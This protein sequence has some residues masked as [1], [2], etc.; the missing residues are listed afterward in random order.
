MAVVR[1]VVLALLVA[2]GGRYGGT[3]SA[4]SPPAR[5]I[6]AAALPYSVLDARTGRQVD[7]QSFWATVGSSRVVCV[8]EDHPNPHHHW[9]QLEVVSQVVG[10][11]KG[12]PLGLGMEMFQRPYQGVLDDYAARRIDTPALLSRS[13]WE[14]RWGYDYGLYGPTIDKARD[15]GAVLLALNAPRELVK[16]LVRQGLEAFTDEE[17]RLV[18]ELVL[19][20]SQHRAWFDATMAEIGG[21]DGGNPHATSSPHD[22]DSKP[23]DKPSDKPEDVSADAPAKMPS[24]DRIYAAQVLWDETMADAAARWSAAN[25]T[26]LLVVLAGNGHCHDSAI[27]R[28]VQR[29]GVDRVISIQPVLD[30]HG[31]VSRALA[32]PINDYVVVLELPPEAKAGM[33]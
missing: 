12:A 18:P 19:D 29:R 16:K 14:E 21:S 11:R 9:F 13:G 7:K 32:S 25:P 23:G 6:A 22:M 17:R 24:A 3:R 26:G 31:K 8:G 15:A 33:Q 20:D 4:E 27:V 10:R 1:L 2:C 5:G 30:V 28:R